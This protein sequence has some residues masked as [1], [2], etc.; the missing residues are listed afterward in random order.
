MKENFMELKFCARSEN[1]GFARTCVASFCLG[2]NPSVDD[3]NDIKTAVSEAV[4]NCVVHAYPNKK[5]DVFVSAK[6]DDGV[7][8]ICVADNG[9]GISDFDKAKEAFYTTKQKEE[10]SGLGFTIM[11][12]FMDSMSVEKN[13]DKGVKVTLVKRLKKQE[14]SL[15]GDECV[16]SV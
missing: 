3:L 16:R 7:L 15:V 6:I 11:E 4:T 5:G 9:V 12:S 10:R 2:L 13:G 8:T 1:E 14:K